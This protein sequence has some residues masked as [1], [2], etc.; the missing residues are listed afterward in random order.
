MGLIQQFHL[1]G[2][3]LQQHFLSGELGFKPK[4]EVSLQDCCVKSP[5]ANHFSPEDLPFPWIDLKNPNNNFQNII[6]VI[7]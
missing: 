2:T 5:F 7:A 3:G 6:E 1:A 4:A